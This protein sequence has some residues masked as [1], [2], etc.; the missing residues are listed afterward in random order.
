[1]KL[2]FRANTLRLRVNQREVETLANGD[3]LQ[4]RIVFPGANNLAYVLE[5]NA[6]PRGQASFHGG[7]IRVSVPHTEVKDWAAS[8]T[9]L[10]LY[11]DLPADGSVLKVAIEK[12]LAC[13]DGPDEER[14]PDAFPRK[15][16]THC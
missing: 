4:E 3:V 1:M 10:G 9:S 5:T 16:L 15:A 7:T 11:F 13:V 2:R 12:D 8:S 6:G 14:D